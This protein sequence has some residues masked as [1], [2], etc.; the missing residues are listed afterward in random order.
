M[1]LS[2][3]LRPKYFAYDFCNMAFQLA[4]LI[5]IHD[6]D[7]FPLCGIIV[8]TGRQ[9][10]G[11]TLSITEQALRIIKEYPKLNVYSNYNIDPRDNR[12]I[13]YLNSFDD[14]LNDNNGRYGCLALTDE[15]QNLYNNKTSKEADYGLME[16]I[17]QNRKS[18]RLILTSTQQFYFL[19]KAIRSQVVEVRKIISFKILNLV[20]RCKPEL[21]KDMTIV[22][23]RP[24]GFYFYVPSKALFDSYDTFQ[25]IEAKRKTPKK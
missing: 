4:F 8:Y 1:H 10:A 18:H 23:T 16:C 17:C 2:H 25:K 24:V 13:Y 12:S 21:D 9:G 19:D 7:E 3:K 20:I 14:L 22:K 15:L 6:K 11:K 5:F